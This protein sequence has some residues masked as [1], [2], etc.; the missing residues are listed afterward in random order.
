[1]PAVLAVLA[2]AAQVLGFAPFALWPLALVTAAVWLGTLANVSVRAAAWRGF[3]FAFGLYLAGVSWV[4]MSIHVYGGAP[5]LLAV[6][7]VLL[8][9]AYLAAYAGLAFA[10]AWW[11]SPLPWVRVLLALPATW[12]AAEMGR[13]LVLGGFPWLGLGYALLDVPGMAGLYA[14]VGVLGATL[15]YWW[16]AGALAMMVLARPALPGRAWRT[17]AIGAAVA[18]PVGIALIAAPLP[19]HWTTAV[20]DEVTV[21]LIQGNMAQDQKWLPENLVPTLERYTAL[22]ERHTDADLVIWPEV[23]IPASRH[24]VEPWFEKWQADAVLHQQTVL[25]GVITRV[26]GQAYNTVY[27]LGA[28]PDRYVKQ[29]LVPFGEYFPVPGWVRPVFDWLDLPF[30]D[31]RTDLPG[32]SQLRHD[33]H[34]LAMSICFEDVFPAEF[35]RTARGSDLLV[36]VTNDAW[37]AGTLAPYQHLQIARARAAENGRPLLRVANTGISAI[38]D[39]DGQVTHALPW[40]ETGTL[41]AAVTGRRGLTPFARWQHQILGAAAGIVVILLLLF[42]PLAFSISRQAAP[43]VN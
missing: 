29:H 34:A 6:L 22:T 41:A 5:A 27:A 20:S 36:N 3:A 19:T 40:G 37:F 28:Q 38:I 9:A 42:R 25:A 14:L 12:L 2:G 13:G 39:G 11:L 8:L 30:S 26:D 33:T 4:Y 7:L 15:I 10:L 43:T 31:I 32:A 24:I 16:L 1:M 35:A 17:R 21:A 23:A 18:L